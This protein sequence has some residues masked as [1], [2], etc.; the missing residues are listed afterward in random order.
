[1]YV[2][3]Y[4]LAGTIRFVQGAQVCQEQ[5][6]IAKLHVCEQQ[7]ALF[8]M[9]KIAG[10]TQLNVMQF[11]RKL[12]R[13]A[14]AGMPPEIAVQTFH[15]GRLRCLR[16]D[17]QKQTRKV[18][19]ISHPVSHVTPLARCTSLKPGVGRHCLFQNRQHQASQQGGPGCR[20][21]L[22]HSERTPPANR[23]T[24]CPVVTES[25]GFISEGEYS[26]LRTRLMQ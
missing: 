2:T 16:K 11:I 22:T 20:C 4:P 19:S 13:V 5:L 23:C 7:S 24:R 26:R 12:L 21:D 18:R 15:Y 8:V 9:K 14:K 17:S 25:A 3:L 1:M 10:G 6:V